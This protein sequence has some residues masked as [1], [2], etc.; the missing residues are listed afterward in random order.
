MLAEKL[1]MT[2]VDCRKKVSH[3][4]AQ[5]WAAYF[6]E[7]SEQEVEQRKTNSLTDYYLMQNTMEV[8]LLRSQWS[9]KRMKVKFEDF[10]LKFGNEAEETTPDHELA[11]QKYASKLNTTM[12]D[13]EAWQQSLMT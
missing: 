13:I 12:P 8:R 11:P 2:V 10:L 7:K 4:E 9:K 5:G 1:G 6:Q 3:R